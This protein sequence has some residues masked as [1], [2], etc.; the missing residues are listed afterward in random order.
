MNTNSVKWVKFDSILHY[1][2]ALWTQPAALKGLSLFPLL[3]PSSCTNASIMARWLFVPAGSAGQTCHPFYF[4]QSRYWSPLSVASFS[5]SGISVASERK[6]SP[7][8]LSAAHWPRIAPPDKLGTLIRWSRMV[9]SWCIASKYFCSMAQQWNNI[10]CH[11]WIAEKH[12]VY[13]LLLLSQLFSFRPVIVLEL[14]YVLNE[15]FI[16]FL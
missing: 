13:L 11:G 10:G 2:P 1:C 4:A 8:H 14:W 16:I 12:W 15:Y 5:L 9:K 6:Y 3:M 7:P